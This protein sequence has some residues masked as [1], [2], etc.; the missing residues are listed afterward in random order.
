[1]I[2]NDDE[3]KR[4]KQEIQKIKYEQKK[5][6]EKYVK[7]EISNFYLSLIDY[8]HELDSIHIK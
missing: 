6:L 4:H 7:K 2:E 5:R 8:E 1:M 3:I